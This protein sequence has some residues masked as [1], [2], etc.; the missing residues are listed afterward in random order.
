MA[1]QVFSQWV[2]VAKAQNEQGQEVYLPFAGIHA[3]TRD[4]KDEVIVGAGNMVWTGSMWV[5]VSTQNR[6]PV[7]A[8]VSGAVDVSDRA[9]RQLGQVTLSGSVVEIERVLNMTLEA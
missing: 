1:Q 4:G 2:P 6:L 5:P 8:A 3:Q 7:D 9:D